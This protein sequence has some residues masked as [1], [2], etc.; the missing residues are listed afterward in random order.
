HHQLRLQQLEDAA[1]QRRP[2]PHNRAADALLAGSMA[3]VRDTAPGG[4]STPGNPTPDYPGGAVAAAAAVAPNMVSIASLS[5][6]RRKLLPADTPRRVCQYAFLKNDIVWICKECQADET[7][8]LCND[9]FRSS[10]HEGHEVYFYHAQ[11]GGCCD[12]GDP[13]AWDSRGFC[14]HHGLDNRDPLQEL[15]RGLITAGS[16]VMDAVQDFLLDT[17]DS[18]VRSFD[19]GSPW[20]PISGRS[21]E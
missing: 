13:D 19:L 21:P 1:G 6:V 10:D 15:P 2:S 5:D 20:K 7:C 8:V 16:T 17:A 12:C 11:A 14:H 9:C 3:I 18:V 4:N